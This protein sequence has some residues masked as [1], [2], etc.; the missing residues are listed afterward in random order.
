MHVT[1]LPTLYYGASPAGALI[2]KQNDH[3]KCILCTGVPIM[4]VELEGGRPRYVS[5]YVAWPGGIIKN[6]N[7]P[8]T[9]RFILSDVAATRRAPMNC[10]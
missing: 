3:I 9:L 2:V 4:A 5:M 1:Y 6:E 10:T 7:E 8:F